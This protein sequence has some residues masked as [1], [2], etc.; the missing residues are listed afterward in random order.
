MPV[1]L[2]CPDPLPP[3][4][5]V[6]IQLPPPDTP[7]EARAFLDHWRPEIAIFAEGELRP[8]LIEDAARRKIPLL[9]ADARA[10]SA[11]RREGWFP[12]LIRWTLAAFHQILA[13][14][15]AAARAFRRAGAPSAAL[16][17]TGRLEEPSA[18]LPCIEAE[19]AALAEILPRGRSGWPPTA[20]GRRGRRHRG[21]PQRPAAGA[22][23][24]ADRAARKASRA[25]ALAER[26]E[27]EGWGVARRASDQEPEPETE[28]FLSTAAENGLW[29]RLAP[30]TFLGGTL[31]GH[32]L[33]RDPMEAAAL[34][35]AIL[36]GPRAGAMARPSGGLARRGRRGRCHRRTDLA[37]ALGDL[38]S[39][40]RAARLAHAAWGVA[41]DGAE[42]TE[43]VL[44]VHPPSWTG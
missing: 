12:G 41:S 24:A 38:L 27:A 9:M 36:H 42:V 5:G 1:L 33:P 19:R 43:T 25:D 17:V 13:L 23:V 6:L 21:A 14:D 30:I 35:S 16:S 10:A 32:R 2:T 28:L 11:A 18:A 40:D 29:Y 34:G 39:P 22:S 26:A 15:D 44:A 4:Y 8:A 31:S 7:S 3:L 20:R 37:D